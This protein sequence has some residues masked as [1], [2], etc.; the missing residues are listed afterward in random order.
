MKLLKRFSPDT[1]DLSED[2]SNSPRMK[3]ATI[4]EASSSSSF[5]KPEKEPSLKGLS[6][7]QIKETIQQNNFTRLTIPSSIQTISEKAFSECISLKHVT[8]PS[9]VTTIGSSPF[10]K[11][12]N[13]ESILVDSQ[14]LQLTSIDEVLFSSN[15]YYLEIQGNS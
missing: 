10:S 15:C 11:C 2:I 13:L 1:Q 9:S 6:L 8:I 7:K 12:T 5:D 3:H 4:T 14:N